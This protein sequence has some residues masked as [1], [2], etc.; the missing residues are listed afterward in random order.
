MITISLHKSFGIKLGRKETV[1]PVPL[2]NTSQRPWMHYTLH[3]GGT[4]PPY[5][6]N[7]Q[8]KCLLHYGRIPHL[9]VYYALQIYKHFHKKQISPQKLTIKIIRCS[10]SYIY[11]I[12]THYHPH[13]KS[14][15]L[16]LWSEI[17]RK[18]CTWKY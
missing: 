7:K 13:L 9:W 6:V 12:T 4:E 8:K 14:I 17:F 3:H 1:P 2:S 10:I 11:T 18:F 5:G 15:F 16:K